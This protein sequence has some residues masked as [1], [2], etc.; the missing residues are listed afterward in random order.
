MKPAPV[1]VEVEGLHFYG[2][3]VHRAYLE[4]ISRHERET[5]MAELFQRAVSPGDV[6]VDVGAF[7]GYFAL[8]GVNAASRGRA[9]AFE[10]DPRDFP[11]LS[12]NIEANGLSDRVQALPT[13]LSDR[14]GWVTFY[15]AQEDQTQSSVYPLTNHGR[16]VQ[17]EA[18]TLDA[19]LGDTLPDI[20]KID[21]EGAELQALEGM[22]RSIQRGRPLLFVEWNPGALIRAG[23]QPEIL[24]RRLEELGYRVELIDEDRRRVMDPVFPDGKTYVNL[25]CVPI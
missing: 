8:L 22:T 17:V 11:W 2:D 6:I 24:L 10:P 7:L 1:H 3:E 19:F 18:V 25:R 12:H 4:A 21:V 9:Y 5:Y 13:A 23:A 14:P 16:S 20:V 15:L